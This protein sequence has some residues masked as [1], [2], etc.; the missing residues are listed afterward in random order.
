MMEFVSPFNG[1]RSSLLSSVASN[2]WPEHHFVACQFCNAVRMVTSLQ[3]PGFGLCWLGTGRTRMGRRL[4]WI[5]SVGPTCKYSRIS[6]GMR[7]RFMLQECK[8]RGKRRTSNTSSAAIISILEVSICTD[9][10]GSNPYKRIYNLH[11]WITS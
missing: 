6:P 8:Q 1:Y 10:E 2:I 9:V 3:F 7:N 5:L 4:A 11:R